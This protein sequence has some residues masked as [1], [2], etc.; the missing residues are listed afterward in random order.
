[1]SSFTPSSY[2][3]IN[4]SWNLDGM[5]PGELLISTVAP[6]AIAPAFN[7]RSTFAA[8]SFIASMLAALTNISMVTFAGTDDT[9]APPRVR[10]GWMRM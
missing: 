4:P 9:A 3:S 5:Y 8:A 6:T 10:I 1:M 2:S 7:A